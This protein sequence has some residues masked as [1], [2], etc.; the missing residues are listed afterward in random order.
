MCVCVFGI[1][2]A[3]KNLFLSFTLSL[4]FLHSFI[5]RLFF[6]PVVSATAAVLRS[7]PLSLSLS[8]PRLWLRLLWLF[9]FFLSL[10]LS[11]GRLCVPSFLIGKRWSGSTVSDGLSTTHRRSQH[12]SLLSA[13]CRYVLLVTFDTATNR[14]AYIVLS[15]PVCS[16]CISTSLWD[17][18]LLLLL[19]YVRYS[20]PCQ[21]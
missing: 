14:N 2:T 13:R 11:C 3:K 4:S 5:L 18:P 1:C 7:L 19:F 17:L 12:E 20:P 15:E 10:T 9:S 6:Y 16:R 21:T 8:S